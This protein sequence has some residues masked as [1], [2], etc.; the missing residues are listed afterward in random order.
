MSRRERQK[1]ARGE[2]DLRDLFIRHGF[3]ARRDGRLDADLVHD[4]PG[5]HVE[6][7]RCEN[8]SVPKWLR[9]VREEA[10]DRVPALFFR[11][12]REEWQVIVPAAEYLQAK[13]DQS[14]LLDGLG[15]RHRIT[16]ATGGK[17]P[18]AGRSRSPG[19]NGLPPPGS[20]EDAAGGETVAAT[21]DELAGQMKIDVP[22]PG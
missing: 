21:P 18:L 15:L 19:G 20:E 22:S 13:A 9:Q 17:S 4:I 14:V 2:R 16:P 12:S 5:V 3:S 11:R 6:C 8:L 7:K 10:G 1:G